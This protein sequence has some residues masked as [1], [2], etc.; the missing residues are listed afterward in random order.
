MKR[1]IKRLIVYHLNYQ[2]HAKKNN[3]ENEA[4]RPLEPKCEHESLSVWK[5]SSQNGGITHKSFFPKPPQIIISQILPEHV[6]SPTA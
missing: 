4:L 1:I 3:G 2:N 6:Q 5:N